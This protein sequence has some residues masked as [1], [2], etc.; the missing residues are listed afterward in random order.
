MTVKGMEAGT[1]GYG[2][3][4]MR[5]ESCALWRV[6]DGP[7]EGG[8]IA[9][10]AVAG[11]TRTAAARVAGLA[12]V[13]DVAGT[14]MG[15]E[16]RVGLESMCVWG[17]Q[18]AGRVLSVRG[19]GVLGCRG[20]ERRVVVGERGVVCVVRVREVVSGVMCGV[21]VCGVGRMCRMSV[22]A[23]RVCGRA[24]LPRMALCAHQAVVGAHTTPAHE[25]EPD[26]RDEHANDQAEEDGRR[27]PHRRR[28]RVPR[29][30]ARGLGQRVGGVHVRGE[31]GLHRG[32]HGE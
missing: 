2:R 7:P 12:G 15:L 3:R 9:P 30:R 1:K 24:D 14:A 29:D 18:R 26:E 11:I 27:A 8:E 21:V 6:C 5:S 32:R 25:T 31:L 16:E 22:D 10:A 13:T 28:A 20:D 19:M 17:R 4:V 23:R